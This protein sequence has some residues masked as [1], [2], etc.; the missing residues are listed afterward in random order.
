MLP[1][2][3][4]IDYGTKR[5]GLAVN[6]PLGITVQPLPFVENNSA[7]IKALQ[8]IIQEKEIKKIILGLPL[9]LSG[10]EELA[11]QKV[12]GFAEE[13]RVLN[14]PLEFCDERLTTAAAHKM[15]LQFGISER[16]RRTK[17]DSLAACVL[18]DDYL[19]GTVCQK[20]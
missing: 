5:I 20:D 16:D 13:L 17:V 2:Y 7:K 1:R 8:K 12:R 11:A 15:M 14:L 3:L 4:A 10:Q 9:A 18:L 6:D 19:R